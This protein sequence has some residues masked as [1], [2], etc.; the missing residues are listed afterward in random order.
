MDSRNEA[1]LTYLEVERV[2]PPDT[3]GPWVIDGYS[4][5]THPDLCDR[6]EEINAAAGEP[7]ELRYLFG[8]PALVAANGVI[9]AFGGGTYVFAVRL[10]RSQVDPPLLGKI[11]DDAKKLEALTAHDWTLVNPWTVAVLKDE[12]LQQ[13]AALVGRAVANSAELKQT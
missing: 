8:K 7:A 3:N 12:G 13:L 9:V 11:H 6:V 2:A 4:L 1:V 10:P 5:S